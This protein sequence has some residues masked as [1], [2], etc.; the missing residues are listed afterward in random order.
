MTL[1]EFNNL[2]RGDI[3]CDIESQLHFIVHDC[4]VQDNGAHAFLGVA[5]VNILVPHEWKLIKKE[6]QHG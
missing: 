6:N 5:T 4:G 3:V 1:D 2:K